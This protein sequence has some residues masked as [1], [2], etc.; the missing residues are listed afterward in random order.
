MRK[1]DLK[2][3][4]V[5]LNRPTGAGNHGAFNPGQTVL[6]AGDPL[7]AFK[8]CQKEFNANLALSPNDQ[9]P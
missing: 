1:F 2:R 7:F 5:G 3:L 8:I 6:P 4:K 9:N